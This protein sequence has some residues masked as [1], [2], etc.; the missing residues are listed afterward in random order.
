MAKSKLR[1]HGEGSVY[2]R[3]DGRWTASMTLEDHSRKYF[4]GET[5]KE[6]YEKL[7]KALH[8][9]KQGTLLVGP[10]QML[11]EHLEYRLEEGHKSKI[12]IGTYRSNQGVLKFPLV[13]GF[14]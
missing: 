13:P 8:E 3:K 4:Y 5:R 14:G 7:Q 11:K 9:Q 12:C 6:A 1:G 10:Q 2:R